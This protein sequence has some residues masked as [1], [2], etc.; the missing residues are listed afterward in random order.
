MLPT[1]TA[2]KA[3]IQELLTLTGYTDAINEVGNDGRNDLTFFSLAIILAATRNFSS[4]NKLGV[5]GF[6]PVYKVK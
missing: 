1:L 5:G 4:D 2:K 6:G 3:E